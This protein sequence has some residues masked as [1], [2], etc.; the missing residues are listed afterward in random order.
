MKARVYR[1]TNHCM[2]VSDKYL[3]LN[4]DR[5]RGF[6]SKFIQR[7]LPVFLEKCSLFVRKRTLTGI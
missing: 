5:G 3:I 7:I 6:Y 2:K 1:Y 4:M